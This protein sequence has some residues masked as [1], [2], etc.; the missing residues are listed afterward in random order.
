MSD[1]NGSYDVVAHTPMGDQK[2]TITVLVAGD[3]FTGTSSGAMGSSDLSGTVDG[4]TIK[5]KQGITVPMP[6][7]LDCTA[8][9]ADGTFDGTVDTGSF[10]AFPM[11]GAKVA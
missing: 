1:L 7:T 8:T 5:W 11:K 6:L 2:M 10:G 3:S 9:I 4:N